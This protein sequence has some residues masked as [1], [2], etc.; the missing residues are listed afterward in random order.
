[1]TGAAIDLHTTNGAG[2]MV[3]SANI[4]ASQAR[5]AGITVTVRTDPIY[6]GTRYLKL[7]F[8]V[9]Y[10]GTRN[11]LPQVSASML[12][13]RAP[14]KAAVQRDALAAQVRPRLGLHQPLQAGPGRG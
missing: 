1:M 5:A 10:W 14:Y 6:Y 8:S 12:P 13:A 4:F 3:E 2:G 9:D 7:P 11:Y